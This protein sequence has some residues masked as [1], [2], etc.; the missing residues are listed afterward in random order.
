[1]AVMF[2][3][4]AVMESKPDMNLSDAQRSPQW[5]MSFGIFNQSGQS[6]A[7]LTRNGLRFLIPKARVKGPAVF[8]KAIYFTEG[9][10]ICKDGDAELALVENPPKDGAEPS[11]LKLI[12]AFDNAGVANWKPVHGARIHHRLTLEALQEA[13]NTVYIQELDIVVTTHFNVTSIRHPFSRDGLMEGMRRH[14][15]KDASTVFEFFIVDNRQAIADRYMNFQGRVVRIH[16]RYMPGHEEGFYAKHPKPS[17]VGGVSVEYEFHRLSLEE[18]EKEYQLFKTPEEAQT[19]GFSKEALENE[20]LRLKREAMLNQHQESQREFERNESAA[21]RKE[22]IQREK[23]RIEQ[24][25]HELKMHQIE[26]E[27]RDKTIKHV[28]GIVTAVIGLS[29]TILTLVAKLGKAA[30]APKSK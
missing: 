17:T 8:D 11:G 9:F 4:T 27:S 5:T 1:M 18:A 6:I 12:K 20:S 3:P 30:P 24:R 22:R 23:D 10:E 2:I 29:A 25:E 16:K 14:N 21:E 15:E 7:V 26:I 19:F 13:G 28:V